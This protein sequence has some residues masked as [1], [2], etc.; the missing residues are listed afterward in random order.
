MCRRRRPAGDRC[1]YRLHL[2]R[3]RVGEKSMKVVIA[4]VFPSTA[5]EKIIDTFP[6]DWDIAFSRPEDVES[7]IVTADVL[8]PEHIQ[9]NAALLEKAPALKLVQTGAGYNNV[10][11]DD[12]TRHWVK[13]CNAAGVNANAVAEHVL[14]FVLCWYKNLI[15]LDGFMKAHGDE[16]RLD[17]TGSELAG[18]T[19]GLIGLGHIGQRVAEL[20]RAFDMQVLGYS[21]NVREV[22]GV[23]RASLEELCPRAIVSIHVPLTDDTRHMVNAEVFRLMKR[24]AL[25]IN[26]SR[27][28][29]VDEKQ[30]VQALVSG[31]ISGACLDVYKNEPLGQDSPLREMGQVILTPHTAGL[32][33]GGQVPQ[34]AL[35]VLCEQHS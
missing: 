17:Y 33:D 7:E 21:R 16:S 8:I 32:P 6:S 9:V 18:K 34:E 29:V 25:L 28:A 20:C 24:S 30:L 23:E 26:T 12:C 19:I 14:A 11:L 3:Q 27:G 10:N 31:Q 5:R 13:V 4:G 2:A 15:Y 22:P 1:D 35:R